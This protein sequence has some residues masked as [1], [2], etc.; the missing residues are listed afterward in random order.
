MHAFAISAICLPLIPLAKVDSLTHE[1][2]WRRWVSSLLLPKASASSLTP[3][4]ESVQME[5]H[6]DRL[7]VHGL[8][9]SIRKEKADFWIRIQKFRIR[10]HQK[11]LHMKRVWQPSQKFCPDKPFC[12]KRESLSVFIVSQGVVMDDQAMSKNG[13]R[14]QVAQPL[15]NA[16]RLHLQFSAVFANLFF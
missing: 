2:H 10:I 13:K 8:H 15:I 12:C 7:R 3:F 5:R 4:S 1:Q 16:S 11:V 6:A 9:S 14:Q